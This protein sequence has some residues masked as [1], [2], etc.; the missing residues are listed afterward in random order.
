V[1][2]LLAIWDVS[3]ARDLAWGF[4]DHLRNLTGM[5]REIALDAL[6]QLAGVIGR[7]LLMPI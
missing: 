4:A 1:G 3:A 5:D 2:R 7:S 6:D